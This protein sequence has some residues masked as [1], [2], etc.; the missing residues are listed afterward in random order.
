VDSA[1]LPGRSSFDSHFTSTHNSTLSS[2][3]EQ[4]GLTLSPI[5]TGYIGRIQLH[6]N[7]FNQSAFRLQICAIILAPTLLCIAIYVTLKH[8]V[9]SLNPALSRVRPRLYPLIFVPADVSC[10]ILQAIGGGVAAVASGNN[11]SLLLAGDRV[12]IAGIVLQVVV[13]GAFGALSIDYFV[14]VRRWIA[15]SSSSISGDGDV[16]AAQ[17]RD[18][19]RAL[20]SDKRFQ[21]F[22]YAVAGA[23]VGIFIRCIYRIAEM[24][25]GWG[26][27]IMRDEP[28]FI[29]LEGL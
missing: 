28:S 26:S 14:R 2:I 19:A 13:L 22:F 12:I 6:A 8:A 4:D 18:E 11:A 1:S 17:Q 16:D 20:W 29:V 15:A 27:T 9:L 3:L 25:G 7:P 5:P 21:R 10:L 24:A 23:Y